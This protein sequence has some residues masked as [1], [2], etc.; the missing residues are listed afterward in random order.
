LNEIVDAE[1]TREVLKKHFLLRTVQ[2]NYTPMDSLKEIFG[3]KES[4]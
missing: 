1:D 3:E 2:K 4:E